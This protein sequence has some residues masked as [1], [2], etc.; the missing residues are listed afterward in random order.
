MKKYFKKFY[1]IAIGLFVLS[2]C[3]CVKITSTPSKKSD[4]NKESPAVT[5][6]IDEKGGSLQVED[7]LE[8]KIPENALLAATE[9]SAKF[10]NE[11]PEEINDDGEK[12][13]PV[14]FMGMAEFGPSGTVFEEPVEVSL[15]LGKV[16]AN[17]EV[18]IYC[19]DEEEKIWKYVC[20]GQV[21]GTKAKFN[22]NHFSK[23]SA[24]DI[25][26]AMMDYFDVLVKA[27]APNDTKIISKFK[28]YLINECH[29]M[30]FITIYGD[31]YYRP[32]NLLV[33]GDYFKNG[34]ENKNTL[35]DF[36]GE[37]IDESK[38]LYGITA[39]STSQ[40]EYIKK[41]QAGKASSTEN[42]YLSRC[43]ASIQ[44]E[45]IEPEIDLSVTN[46][47]LKKGESCE[48]TIWCT[49]PQSD[50]DLDKYPLSIKTTSAFSVSKTNVTTDEQGRATV[51]VTRKSDEEG[52]ITVSFNEHDTDGNPVSSSSTFTFDKNTDGINF[53]VV[54]D[55]K[56]I[57]IAEQD[58]TFARGEIVEQ[59]CPDHSFNCQV[60]IEG[61]CE[62]VPLN[63]EL[64]NDE[65]V[66]MSGIK[67][68]VL[69][70]ATLKGVPS[71]TKYSYPDA[72]EKDVLSNSYLGDKVFLY[73]RSWDVSVAYNDKT[74]GVIGLLFN[75]GT[76]R[77]SLNE[78]CNPEKYR[79]L[80]KNS[81][82]NFMMACSMLDGD[83]VE[84]YQDTNKGVVSEKVTTTIKD[85]VDNEPSEDNGYY[86]F[87]YNVYPTACL[88]TKYEKGTK[89]IEVS[90]LNESEN[91]IEIPIDYMVALNWVN[92]KASDL[93]LESIEGTITFK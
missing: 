92:C 38:T 88:V 43:L 50:L 82:H 65:M 6:L 77:M 29:V 44:Y 66:K 36:Y 60:E 62:L 14:N 7:K 4:G 35:A 59:E 22:V 86:T 84:E 37:E 74:V 34:V 70:K 73:N 40:S 11:I 91:Y 46:T 47:E 27:Y 17:G 55:Y 87:Y 58:S 45:M 18:S 72:Y 81:I 39:S 9:I 28:D 69:G 33:S 31:F 85:Y 61:D 57:V 2:V 93:S 1:S 76:I 48:L 56:N 54:I 5:K 49:D 30:D 63:D 90:P 71:K 24:L 32:R 67:N 68:I 21:D 80:T 64:K 26:P 75:D 78:N 53:K 3:S 15:E 25:T 23:Y 41:V 8:I 89:S 19:F 16:P 12:T 79:N 51:T 52:T 83:T 42:I 10:V 13:I 20:P